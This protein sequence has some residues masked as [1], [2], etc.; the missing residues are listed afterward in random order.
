M[1]EGSCCILDGIDRIHPDI[2]LS[3]Q[4]IVQDRMLFLFDGSRFISD[5]Q[6]N[7]LLEHYSK[8]Q[9]DEMKIYKIHPSFRLIATGSKPTKEKPWFN[10]E[11]LNMFSFHICDD[12]PFECEKSLLLTK[13]KIGDSNLVENLIR[14]KNEFNEFF[15]TKLTI[16][17]LIKILKR[18]NEFK[19]EN[20]E[21]SLKRN[22][23][24]NLQT[25]EMQKLFTNLILKY[26]LSESISEE[27]IK[28]EKTDSHIR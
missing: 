11:I 3:I 26:N 8:D 20:I 17:H 15:E 12:I 9:L 28:I 1:L 6:Y 22:V 7:L 5:A 16:R 27:D 13:N 4:Q 14:F 25:R 21:E 10:A 23:L 19:N 2:L 18:K 24:I